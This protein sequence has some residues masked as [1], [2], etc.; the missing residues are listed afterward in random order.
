[1]IIAVLLGTRNTAGYKV[2]ISDIRATDWV[3]EVTYSEIPPQANQT[4]SQALTNPYVLSVIAQSPAP[5][6]FS[7]EHFGPHELPYTEYT[8]MIR[9]ISE[10]SYQLEDERRKNVLSQGRIQDLTNLLTRTAPPSTQLS[11]P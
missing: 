2:K 8:R 9:Q 1:M 11:L 5:V 10:M 7:K 3:I 6:V 4:I